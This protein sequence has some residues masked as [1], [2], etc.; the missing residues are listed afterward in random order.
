[1]A[2]GEMPPSVQKWRSSA[3][4]T[5]LMSVLRY[6]VVRQLLPVRGAEPADQGAVA[7]VD[8]GLRVAGRGHGVAGDRRLL[9]GHDDREGAQDD[10]PADDAEHH[11]EG[12]PPGP[13]PPPAALDLD[14]SRDRAG[15]VCPSGL[16]ARRA[17]R[18]GGPAA[19]WPGR[20]GLPPARAS[21]DRYSPGPSSPGRRPGCSSSARGCRRGHFPARRRRRGGR[22]RDCRGSRPPGCG[23]PVCPSRWRRNPGR[24]RPSRRRHR[25][26]RRRGSRP[27]RSR[28]R[29]RR[30]RCPRHGRPARRDTE[31]QS[32]QLCCSRV[33][34]GGSEAAACGKSGL[35]LTAGPAIREPAELTRYPLPREFT[36]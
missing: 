21:R 18:P 25:D 27:P 22:S 30:P 24:S 2:V 35:Y 3:A 26:R 32:H 19:R 23:S 31:R 34:A 29:A 12:F 11:A 1:M 28:P 5:A 13:V 17:R 6:L 15:P 36:G 9:V 10:E 16:P 20:L 4:S 8:Q 14:P 33:L 7:G